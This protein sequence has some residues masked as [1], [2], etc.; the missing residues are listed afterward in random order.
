LCARR[1]REESGRPPSRSVL[2]R[3]IRRYERHATG[4]L[5]FKA[6]QEAEGPAAQRPHHWSVDPGTPLWM[7]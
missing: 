2:I 4:W 3:T 6:A 1:I 5:D 7:Q